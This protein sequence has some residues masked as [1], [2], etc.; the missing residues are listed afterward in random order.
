MLD[1][2]RGPDPKLPQLGLYGVSHI[3]PPNQAVAT[4]LQTGSKKR[5]GV[6]AV[7][8][9]LAF[10]RACSQVSSCTRS[11]GGEAFIEPIDY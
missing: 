2:F 10:D 7:R 8:A 5:R 3:S 6:L 4:A 1:G 9:F 11:N